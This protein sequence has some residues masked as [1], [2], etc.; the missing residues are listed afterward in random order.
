LADSANSCF[1]KLSVNLYFPIRGSTHKQIKRERTWVVVVNP[2]RF[3][4][5]KQ[6]RAKTDKRDS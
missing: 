1:Q 2:R 6:S 4:V 3:E 5:I